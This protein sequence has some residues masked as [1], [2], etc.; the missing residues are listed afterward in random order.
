MG[1]FL[2]LWGTS[3]FFLAIQE[4]IYASFGYYTTAWNAMGDIKD[5][6]YLGIAVVLILLGLK[7][8]GNKTGTSSPAPQPKS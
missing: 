1:Y 5:V 2:I 8:L 3:F 7:V 4:F 6:L